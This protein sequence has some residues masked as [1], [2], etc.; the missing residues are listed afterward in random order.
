MNRSTSTLRRT[1][2][3]VALAGAAAFGAVALAPAASAAQPAVDGSSYTL[4]GIGGNGADGFLVTERGRQA[5]FYCKDEKNNKRH[6][7][8]QADPG[9]APDR[10]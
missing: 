3:T 2:V 8:C 4:P 6:N 9:A 1:A 5:V 7:I 10:F